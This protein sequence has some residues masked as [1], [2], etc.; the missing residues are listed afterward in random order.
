MLAIAKDLH[1]NGI[2]IRGMGDTMYAPDM[3]IFSSANLPK[4]LKRLKETGLSIPILT[5]GAYFA[6]AQQPGDPVGEACAYRPCGKAGGTV[7][8][9]DGGAYAAAGGRRS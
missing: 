3:E 4:T 5:S 1:M 8:P 9:C 6:S 7:C 2:E